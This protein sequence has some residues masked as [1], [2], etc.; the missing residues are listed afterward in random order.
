M[1]QEIF[2]KYTEFHY[3]HIF[4]SFQNGVEKSTKE[5]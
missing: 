4:K 2:R 5:Y 1:W 3:L